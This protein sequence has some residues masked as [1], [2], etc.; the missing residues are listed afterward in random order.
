MLMNRITENIFNL[1]RVQQRF[2]SADEMAKHGV[3]CESADVEK[4]LSHHADFDRFAKVP[5]CDQCNPIHNKSQSCRHPSKHFVYRILQ[6]GL[7]L[8]EKHEKPKNGET[9]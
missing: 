8:L 1:A 3:G 6:K 9:E 5:A 4:L 7:A 2:W